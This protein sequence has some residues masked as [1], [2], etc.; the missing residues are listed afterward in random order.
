MNLNFPLPS[1][2]ESRN[3]ID[4]GAPFQFTE[5]VDPQ[6]RAYKFLKS[7]MSVV[8]IFPCYYGV[9]F[10]PKGTIE[11]VVGGQSFKSG[12]KPAINYSEAM[13]K[14]EKMCRAYGVSSA[15]A[16]RLYL[17]DETTVTDQVTNQ[18]KD[19]FFQEL[20]DGLRSKMASV[21]DIAR[22]LNATYPDKM[23]NW[24]GDKMDS[25]ANEGLNF[26]NLG[27]NQALQD[28]KDMA[29][30]GVKIAIKGNKIALP[31]IWDTSDYR[32][33]FS[34]NLKLFSPYGTP[35]AVKKF[36]I[37]PLIHL[38]LISCPQT[39]DGVSYGQPFAC[40]VK[41][42]GI[43]RL[44]LAV[45]SSLTLRRGGSDTS[46]NVFKQPLTIDVSIDFE[47]LVSGIAAYEAD[48]I[49]EFD[50]SQ[51][52][53]SDEFGA[54]N[55]DA[56]SALIPTIGDLVNALKPMDFSKQS[57]RLGSIRDLMQIGQDLF[58]IGDFGNLG[59]LLGGVF[60]S[61]WSPEQMA[62]Q[63][64]LKT[65]TNSALNQVNFGNGVGSSLKS[66]LQSLVSNTTSGR[67]YAY[68]SY[69]DS[70]YL[71]QDVY[72]DPYYSNDPEFVTGF[73]N[74][75]SSHNRYYYQSNNILTSTN[76][77]NQNFLSGLNT[78]GSLTNFTQSVL[79][80]LL[81]DSN[82]INS[83]YT[84]LDQYRYERDNYYNT[85]HYNINQ[86]RTYVNNSTYY[87]SSERAERLQRLS[88]YQERVNRMNRNARYSDNY[89][90]SARQNVV[91][92]NVPLEKVLSLKSNSV[93]SI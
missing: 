80:S 5:L 32:P 66:M 17:T 28:I 85:T 4:I 59:G 90:N 82:S 40:S 71:Y 58:N 35:A 52:S 62:F 74:L 21:T 27:D 34:L 56:P 7:R 50:R 93:W 36:I 26:L 76:S 19:N 70:Q 45:M 10:D 67:S 87:S 15:S 49:S 31:K 33:A 2:L 8:D 20:V 24:T 18:F 79:Q 63:N 69:Q 44:N 92:I 3:I 83:D 37:E 30:D 57:N 46:F 68:S 48:S 11:K 54:F 86:R 60:G 13:N 89:M 39:A 81:N 38:L 77:Y 14:F 78:N 6:S 47:P 53:S 73:E 43:T 1:G 55:V 29:I 91:E 84:T 65:A 51:F 41:A 22:S 25:L 64:M 9:N 12:F 42:Y 72:N 16:L 88:A 61:S 75:S 23:A